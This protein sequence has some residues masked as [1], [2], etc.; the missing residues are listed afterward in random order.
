MSA[1][2]KHEPKPLCQ[3]LTVAHTQRCVCRA[4]NA[5]GTLSVTNKESKQLAQDLGVLQTARDI[6]QRQA[7]EPKLKM[8]VQDVVSVLTS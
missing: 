1:L 7:L 2:S 5:V 4:L 3:S 6:Q 8:V